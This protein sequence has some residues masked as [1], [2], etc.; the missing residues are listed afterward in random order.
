MG[1][2]F[3]NAERLEADPTLDLVRIFFENTATGR[4]VPSGFIT[5]PIGCPNTRFAS[6]FVLPPSIDFSYILA[7]VVVVGRGGEL[8][9]SSFFNP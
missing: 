3:G 2:C 6:S 4:R 1:R 5:F 8:R 9:S 7:V